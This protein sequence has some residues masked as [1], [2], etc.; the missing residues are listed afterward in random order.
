MYAIPEPA[1]TPSNPRRAPDAFRGGTHPLMR[2]C[3]RSTRPLKLIG[4]EEHLAPPDVRAAWA[5]VDAAGRDDSLALFNSAELTRSLE[6]LDEYRLQRMDESGVD[7]QVLSLTTPAVQ[8]LARADAVPLARRVN[9]QIAETVR[10]RPDRF[11]GFATL[12]TPDPAAAARELQ[13]AVTALGLKGAMLCGRTRERNLDHPEFRPII[14]AAADLRVPLYIH[15]QLPQRAVRDVYYGGFDDALDAAFAGGGIGWHYETG[16]Q[17]LRLVLAGVFDRHPD[18]Q[19][20]L[21]HW[22]EVVLFYLE[23]IDVL[24]KQARTLQRP[25][26]DYVRRNVYVTPSGIFSQSYLRRAIEIL[27]VDRI[28]F[29]TDYPFVPAPNGGARAFLD[30]AALGAEDKAKIAHGNWERLASRV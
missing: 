26:A 14:E 19:I 21:G 1:A 12:P 27:G 25:V 7:V 20:I 15:P 28:M 10:R 2:R 6:D 11:E 18:L 30:Q 5:H 17:L 24:S 8:N 29:S 22:G 16:I 23:R 13:R 3:A 9:D 4:L